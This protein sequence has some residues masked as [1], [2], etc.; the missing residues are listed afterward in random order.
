VSKLF[1]I[2]SFLFIFTTNLAAQGLKKA[3]LAKTWYCS[4]YFNSESFI[5]WP[6]MKNYAECTAK[7]TTTGKL[8]LHHI[9]KQRMDSTYSYLVDKDMVSLYFD[10]KDSVRKLNYKT[11]KLKDKN[12]YEFNMKSRS[13]YVKRR[14]DD[15]I[16]L[17]HITLINGLKKQDIYREEEVT[18]F[19]Q[20]KARRNDS[21]DLA[22]WGQ[23]VGYI[24]DTLLIDSDQYVEHN[25]YR[26]YKDSLHYIAPLLFDTVVRIKVPVKE[27]TGLYGQREPFNSLVTGA[28]ILAMGTGLISVSASILAGEKPIGTTFAQ[29]GVISFLTI[30]VSFGL[31]MAFSKRKYQ[32]SSKGKKKKV[33]IVE[34]HMPNITVSLG[35][36]GKLELRIK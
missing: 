4:C 36:P 20:K 28:T 13:N 30:P 26:S 27:I 34:R 12:A 25:F 2:A 3:L 9:I 16:T 14:K 24:S 5:L 31:G 32:F 21:I 7:F 29:I 35:K 8:V 15:T 22:V 10:V 19:S 6:E 1:T 23:F 18:I 17:D 33:W 11:E